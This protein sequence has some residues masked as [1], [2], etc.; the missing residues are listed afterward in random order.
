M[1][2]RSFKAAS[3]HSFAVHIY[4]HTLESVVRSVVRTV[5]IHRICYAVEE[6]IFEGNYVIPRP[7]VVSVF[8]DI[9]GI[10]T[11]VKLI[12]L[13]AVAVGVGIIVGSHILD[14][15]RYRVVLIFTRC[16]QIG[17]DYSA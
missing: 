17:L 3:R 12:A 10:C 8:A 9:Y 1:R 5:D 16:K 4:A 13:K 6:G 7:T 14:I 11:L 2:E 15:E